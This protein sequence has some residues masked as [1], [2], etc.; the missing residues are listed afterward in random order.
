M[1]ARESRAFLLTL[2]YTR[3]ILFT[4]TYLCWNGKY[5]GELEANLGSKEEKVSTMCSSRVSLFCPP[6]TLKPR[7]GG[8]GNLQ[9]L[10]IS[11][12]TKSFVGI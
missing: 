11:E 5:W 10:E 9:H 1:E 3:N 7:F 2:N 12:R 4:S 8:S 6:L